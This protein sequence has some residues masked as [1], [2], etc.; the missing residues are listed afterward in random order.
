MLGKDLAMIGLCLTLI[1]ND[2]DKTRFMNLYDE[3]KNLMFYV[4]RDILKDD[5]LAE[6]ALQEAFLRIAKNFQKINEISCHKTRNF[7][8]III[9]NISLT[10]LAQKENMADIDTCTEDTLF[11]VSDDCFENVVVSTL[12]EKIM[13]LPNKYRDVLYLH[14]LYGCSYNEIAHLLSI[15]SDAARKRSERAKVIL[16]EKLEKEGFLK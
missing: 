6:D 4:A 11:S 14:N 10:M 8:V 12:T 2:S 16:K 7:V 3:Y 15:S 5:Y 13:E 1:D 9:R